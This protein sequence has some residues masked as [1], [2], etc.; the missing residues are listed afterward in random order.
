[1]LARALQWQR[2]HFE[3]L[4]EVT[5]ETVERILGRLL[6]DAR[7]R[8]RFFIE[9]RDR[10]RRFD[11]LE[12]ERESLSK[13]ESAPIPSLVEMLAERLDPRIVRG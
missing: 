2:C 8:K 11:L 9:R 13:L 1:V 12:H 5:Q 6:T 10:L 3:N 7:F 4:E